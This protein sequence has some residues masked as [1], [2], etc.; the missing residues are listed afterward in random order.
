MPMNRI[1]PLCGYKIIR[2]GCVQRYTVYNGKTCCVDCV[3][4]R[5][6]SDN[7]MSIAKLTKRE[8]E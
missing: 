3:E 5:I 6:R 8:E 4:R 2:S 7:R 1:C